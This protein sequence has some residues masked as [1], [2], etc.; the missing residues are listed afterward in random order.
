MELNDNLSKYM[1]EKCPPSG[2]PAAEVMVDG[3]AL[4]RNFIQYHEKIKNLEVRPDDIWI[5]TFPKCGKL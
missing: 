2:M 4:P 5:V 3:V 1:Q